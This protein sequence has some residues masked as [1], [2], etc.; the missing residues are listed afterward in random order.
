MEAKYKVNVYGH[1]DDCVE[2]DGAI[3]DEIYAYDNAEYIMLNDGTLIK[4]KFDDA[5]VW[6]FSVEKKGKADYSRT[7]GADDD[8]TDRLAIWWD[9]PLEVAWHT[10]NPKFVTKMGAKAAKMAADPASIKGE[11]AELVQEANDFAKDDED[12]LEF[13][14]RL[15]IV[16]EALYGSD[17]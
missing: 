6:R 13:A 8:R 14:M 4:A 7:I 15:S 3:N 10:N 16:K 5:G 2:F 11:L 17:S 12:K 1:S 9:R